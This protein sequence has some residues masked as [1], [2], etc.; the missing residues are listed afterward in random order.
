MKS[1][2]SFKY[3]QMNKVGMLEKFKGSINNKGLNICFS[4]VVLSYSYIHRNI[5]YGLCMLFFIWLYLPYASNK[6]EKNM[7]NDNRYYH[8]IFHMI[9]VGFIYSMVALTLIALALKW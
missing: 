9:S 7:E 3:D 1:K 4:A 6:I 8:N 5:Y 2:S